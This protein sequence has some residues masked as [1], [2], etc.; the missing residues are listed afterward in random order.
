[1]TFLVFN[2]QAAADTALNTINSRYGCPYVAGNYRMD[3]WD[4]VKKADNE[5]KWY[6]VK[7]EER[8]NKTLTE[9]MNNVGA[10]EEIETI[11]DGWL[12]RI[13]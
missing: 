3:E 12:T 13:E 8:L 7:P 10:D 11:P 5:D 9:L 4:V 1:M 6:F 2:T